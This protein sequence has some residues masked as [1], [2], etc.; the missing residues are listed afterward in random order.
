MVL[1]WWCCHEIEDE[2]LKLPVRYDERRELFSMEGFFCS[3]NCMK[4]YALSKYGDTRGGIISQNVVFYRKKKYN[5]YG[6]ISPAPSRYRLKCFGG[7]MTIEDF[8]KNNIK[9]NPN[10]KTE[11]NEVN[12]VSNFINIDNKEKLNKIQKSNEQTDTLKLKR[13]KPLK[14]THNALEMALGIM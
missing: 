9:H 8:K 4:A 3:W 5:I 11:I 2:V 1:C 6:P 13:S 10:N 12:Y 14:K 7:D